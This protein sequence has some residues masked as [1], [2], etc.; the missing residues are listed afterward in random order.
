MVGTHIDEPEDLELLSP[1]IKDQSN[2]P[3]NQFLSFV[4]DPFVEVI[5]EIHHSTSNDLY[6]V[7]SRWGR[8]CLVYKNY[9]FTSNKRVP[10]TNTTYW[11]CTFG[12]KRKAY[13]CMVRCITRNNHLESLAGVHNHPVAPLSVDMDEVTD[14]NITN[15]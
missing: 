2:I 1:E 14:Y 4:P 15:P 11:R 8:V 9:L 12:S 13:P 5:H 6:F 7:R 10:K 3:S